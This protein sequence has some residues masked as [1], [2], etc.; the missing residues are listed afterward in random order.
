MTT[1]KQPTA[2]QVLRSQESWANFILDKLESQIEAR[3]AELEAMGIPVDAYDQDDTLINL[4]DEEMFYAR[5]A[6]EMARQREYIRSK[7]LDGNE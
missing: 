7:Y 1:S 5:Y 6:D 2:T 4:Y 3:E